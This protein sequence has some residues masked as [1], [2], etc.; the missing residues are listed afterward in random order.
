MKK[1]KKIKL[2]KS[3]S[4]SPPNKIQE[5]FEVLARRPAVA[6]CTPGKD[7][8]REHPCLRLIVAEQLLDL[9]PNNVSPHD[10]RPVRRRRRG[11]WHLQPRPPHVADIAL[12][13]ELIGEVRPAE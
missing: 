9:S 13:Q 4:T 8:Q 3:L 1:E 7:P 11:Q 10:S 5:P 12:V 2:S 6:D